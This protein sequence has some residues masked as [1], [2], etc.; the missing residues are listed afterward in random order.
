ML[1]AEREASRFVH[2]VGCDSCSSAC[3]LNSVIRFAIGRRQVTM[4]DRD[5]QFVI[6]SL[7][8]ALPAESALEN[9][10]VQAPCVGRISAIP[11]RSPEPSS[12]GG[13]SPASGCWQGKRSVLRRF[14]PM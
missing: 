10:W 9:R 4:T 3:P 8:S 7:Q 2:P 12:E 11:A 1:A 5:E 14:P 13:W 6:R